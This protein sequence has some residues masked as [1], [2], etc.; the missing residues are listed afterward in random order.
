MGKVWHQHPKDESSTHGGFLEV[1]LKTA[2]YQFI[3]GNARITKGLS[4]FTMD[5]VKYPSV[6][7]LESPPIGCEDPAIC[8]RGEGGSTFDFQG[9][10]GGDASFSVILFT[11]NETTTVNMVSLAN[12]IQQILNRNNDFACAGYTILNITANPPREE[13]DE[14]KFIIY[15]IDVSI[16]F[17]KEE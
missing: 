12:R 9:G 15:V 4:V 17:I 14:K 7:T 16:R 6:F 3:S 2:L 11:G 10:A 8:I 1:D 5:E 13:R